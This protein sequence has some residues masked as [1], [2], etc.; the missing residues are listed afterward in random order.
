MPDDERHPARLSVAALWRYPVKSMAGERLERL[1]LDP[2]RPRGDRLWALRDVERDTVVS[3]RRLPAVLRL[4]ARYLVE[5]D[6]D[7]GAGQV[8]P[9]VITL[10]DGAEVASDDPDVDA[11]LSAVLDR[12][13]RLEALAPGRRVHRLSWHERARS[14]SPAGI[15]RDLGIGSDEALPDATRMDLRALATITRYATPPGTFVDLAP[16]HLVTE[17]SLR[18]LGAALD[19][20]PLDHRRLRPNLVLATDEEGLPE[21]GWRGSDLRV[22][23]AVLR[24]TMPTVRCVVPSREHAGDVPVDRRIT[25]AVAVTAD[26][27]LGAYAAIAVPGAVAVG[28]AAEVRPAPTPGPLRRLAEA[29]LGSVV[30]GSARLL[31][32]PARGTRGSRD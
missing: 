26:R 11:A 3:A 5:P 13:V 16:V 19:A 20:G 27:F 9:V 6:A 18:T 22:G 28:D 4:R 23:A 24:V 21:A 2:V 10:P 14:F 29:G 7:S 12:D 15:R 17:A 31:D 30:R 1:H 25:R 8:P 32:R